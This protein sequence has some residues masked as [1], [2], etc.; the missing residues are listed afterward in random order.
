MS[1][2]RK[3]Y[4]LRKLHSLLGL[5]PVGMFLVIH[6]ALNYTATKG[7][8]AYKN[9]VDLMG[10]LPFRY[11][12]EIVFIALPILYHAILGIH[13]AFTGKVNISR[14]GTFR[15][16]MYVLQ[17]TTGVILVVFIG[18]HVWQTRIAAMY[19]AEVGFSMMADIVANPYMLAFYILG[20]VSAA[21]HFSN[22]LWGFFVTWGITVSAKSQRISTYVSMAVFV[23]MATWG[24]S[25]ILTFLNTQLAK[26]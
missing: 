4:T 2:T 10:G 8:E 6:F 11:F 18:W 22:G 25:I 14:F 16:W 23:A 19:G 9:T 21:F 7:A 24:V 26:M 20:I 15:N 3:E 5:I 17:R 12:I 13:I 1:F